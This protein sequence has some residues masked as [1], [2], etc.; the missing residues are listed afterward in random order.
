MQKQ[1]D[2]DKTKVDYTLKT[3]K[4]AR[5]LRLAVYCDGQFVVTAP[6]NLSQRQIESFILQ[7]AQWVINKINRFKKFPGQALGRLKNKDYLKYKESAL[8]LV[9]TRI[10]HFNQFYNAKIN[11]ISIRNQKTRWGSCSKKGRVSFN[12]KIWLVPNEFADYIIVHEL[13]HLIEFNHSKKFW[14]LVARMI[15]D[16]KEIRF[17]LKKNLF[18]I[19][20]NV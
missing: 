2:F 3:S 9:Q 10:A 4:R 6:Q 14:E 8:I 5:H 1:I 16:Y 18:R 15:P 20:P 13:C 7:K 12:Y 19:S 11:G 17:M